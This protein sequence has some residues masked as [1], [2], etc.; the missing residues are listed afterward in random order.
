MASTSGKPAASVPASVPK[1]IRLKVDTEPQLGPYQPMTGSQILENVPGGVSE[2]ETPGAP[3]YGQTATSGHAPDGGGSGAPSVPSL[4]GVLFRSQ[5][6]DSHYRAQTEHT[7]PYGKI[8]NP[9]TRGM[10]TWIKTYANHVFNGK[11]NVDEAGWQ[12]S[13]PQ[14]RT[15]YMRITPPPHADG[16]S[17]ESY[18]PN[19]QPAVPYT[20]R[21]LPTTGTDLYGTGVLNSDTYGAGQTA[22]GV[23]GQLYTPSPGPPDTTS[24]AGQEPAASAEPMWG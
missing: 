1:S 17:P 8:N 14:Q 16:Y 24:T 20:Q 10:L 9:P 23:G 2:A 21:F 6:I 18:L 15:S 22:G 11:Q 13:S 5:S 19:Q 3:G 4:G 12:Q 7:D